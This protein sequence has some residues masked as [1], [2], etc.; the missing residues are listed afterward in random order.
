ME[1]AFRVEPY[2]QVAVMVR[3]PEEKA[4]ET[5]AAVEEREE[6]LGQVPS[7][8]KKEVVVY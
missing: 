1:I 2:R 3:A 6:V 7:G 8:R 5:W 4:E